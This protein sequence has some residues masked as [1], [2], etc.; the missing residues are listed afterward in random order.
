[1]YKTIKAKTILTKYRQADTWFHIRYSMNLYRGCQHQCIYCDS[2]SECYR[3]ENFEDIIVKENAVEL[4][5]KELKK[6]TRKEIIGTGSMND[7]YMPIEKEIELTRNALKVIRDFKFPVHIITKSSLVLRDIDVIKE[8]SKT[9]ATVSVT[10]TTVND[11]LSAVIEPHATVSSKRFETIKILRENNIQAGVLMMPVLPFITDNEENIEGIVEKSAEVN[12]SYVLPAFGMTL[13][14]RQKNYYFEML[15]NID[16]K[17]Y[18]KYLKYYRGQYSFNS[19]D[20]KRL[21]HFFHILCKKHH[22]KPFID[23][24]SAPGNKQ[25]TIFD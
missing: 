17:I 5:R 1:M 25:L 7:P 9:Y 8:I 13:R 19:P 16:K 20:F 6:I 15:Q 14:D 11:Q 21:Q 4:L 12:A 10:I 23:E 24:Y 3:I 22:I 18:D 2:R